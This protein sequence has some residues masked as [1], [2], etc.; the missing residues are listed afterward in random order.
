MLTLQTAVFSVN[1]LVHSIGISSKG[2]YS[3]KRSSHS[4]VAYLFV[5]A[6]QSISFLSFSRPLILMTEIKKN[7]YHP[8]LVE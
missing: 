3:I 5:F 4:Y 1:Y 2:L 8:Q 7:P 6:L